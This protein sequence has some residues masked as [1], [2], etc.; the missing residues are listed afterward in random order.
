MP[1]RTCGWRSRIATFPTN[2][3][4]RSKG[5]IDRLGGRG[6]LRERDLSMDALHSQ[7]FLLFLFRDFFQ[8]SDVIVGQL[9][10]FSDRVLFVVFG[11]E[12]VFEHL[13]QVLVAVPADVADGGSMLLQDSMDVFGELFPALFGERRNW[14][15]NQTAVVGGIQAQVG[16]SDCFFDGTD[17][18]NIIRLN[19]DERRIR[20]SQLRDLINGSRRSDRKSV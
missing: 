3:G 15:T 6:G 20:G 11:Y 13:F 2:A 9:L 19:R 5:S 4:R 7:D 12:F 18:R 14:D 16:G 17:E 10:D 1:T 8:F